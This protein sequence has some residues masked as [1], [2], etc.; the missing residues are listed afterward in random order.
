MI[1][2]KTGVDVIIPTS[3]MGQYIA[4]GITSLISGSG[5]T[6]ALVRNVVA[7]G[8]LAIENKVLGT[9]ISKYV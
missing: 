1:D 8:I 5:L 7:E 2:G 6:I 3:S 9:D 4:A